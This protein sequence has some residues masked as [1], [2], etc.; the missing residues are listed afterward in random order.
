MKQLA[1]FIMQSRSR[2][3]TATVGFGVGGLVLPPLAVVSSAAVALVGLRAGLN[4]AAVV[5]VISAV[6]LGVLAW[7]MGVE[8]MVGV[9]TGLVQWLPA[10]VL[11]EVLRRTVSWPMMLMTAAGLACGAILLVHA[12]V[13]DVAQMW[14][15]VLHGTLGPLLQQTGMSPQELEQT[16][17]QVAPV[18]T[19]MLAA[20]MVLSLLLAL[21]IA[22]YWQSVLY[23][24]GGF[25]DEFQRLQLGK[26]PA[27]VLVGLLAGA[28]IGQS[29]LLM[30]LGLVLLVV[31]F[32][33]GI[34]LVHG[35]TRQLTMNRFWL[36][37]MYV[38]LV[39]AMPQMMM[40]LAAFGAMD[41]MFDFRARL[42]NRP[43]SG[44]G[45]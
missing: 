31:F 32:I 4:H 18:M 38:L 21:I 7:A 17:R 22:R 39:I 33:Q 28:W 15:T 14:V 9:A 41:S 35:L 2:A 16:F 5:S 27:L 23:N 45:D 11:A 19:G 3:V 8:P 37:G 25:A 34:A 29:D 20:A 6:V 12:A 36:V 13:P 30:E 44:G 40:M 42:G 24:P 26:V 43:G 10:M 1:S